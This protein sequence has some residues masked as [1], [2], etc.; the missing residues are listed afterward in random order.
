MEFSVI[1][2]FRFTMRKT[3]NLSLFLM[4]FMVFS[5]NA[6][7]ANKLLE[8]KYHA[9]VDHQLEVEF[10]FEDDIAVPQVSTQADPAQLSLQFSDS[11]SETKKR[12]FNI[13]KVGVQKLTMHQKQT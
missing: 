3:V 5:P 8:V 4:S 7:S 11:V 2:R 12:S 13:D 9:V 6:F 10:I 1:K